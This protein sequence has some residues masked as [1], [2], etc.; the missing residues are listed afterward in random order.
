MKI[1]I[2]AAD[3][4]VLAER[5]K[6]AGTQDKFIEI[7]LEWIDHADAEIDR[8]RQQV[9]HFEDRASLYTDPAQT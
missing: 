7:A 3:L 6:Q 4:H 1:D 5:S 9:R 8:L 2:T